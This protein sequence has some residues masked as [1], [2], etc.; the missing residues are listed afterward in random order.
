MVRLGGSLLSMV[1]LIAIITFELMINYTYLY[2][3]CV[4]LVKEPEFHKQLKDLGYRT[5]VNL[6]TSS[7]WHYL[8][9][10]GKT[11]NYVEGDIIL[12]EVCFVFIII[13]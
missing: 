12:K 6:P 9:K 3:R 10:G 4:L 8:L 5:L 13:F 11:F 2:V 7:D 1:F